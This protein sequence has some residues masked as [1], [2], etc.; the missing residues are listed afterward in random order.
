MLPELTADQ[1]AV[2]DAIAAEA[3]AARPR[4]RCYLLHGATGSGKTEVYLRLIAAEL[5]AER[6]TL[7]L[8]PEIGLT[9]QLVGRLRDRFGGELAILHSAL[10]ERER[11]A[12]WRRAYRQE[13]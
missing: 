4:F 2:L 7:L 6:Q 13:A 1:R 10:T 12:A 11:F 8:V 9:P 5:A 3:G